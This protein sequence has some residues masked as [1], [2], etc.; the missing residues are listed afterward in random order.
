VRVEVLAR[1]PAAAAA[2]MAQLID[3]TAEADADGAIRVPSGGG[4]AD[5]VF[6]T[7]AQ[8][9]AR[10]PGIALDGLPEEGGAALVLGTRDMAAAAKAIGSAAGTIVGA[11]PSRATGVLLRFVPD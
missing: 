8:L 2:Q 3:R 10:H 6:L 5:F 7:R 9:A 11:A 1:D 4:R